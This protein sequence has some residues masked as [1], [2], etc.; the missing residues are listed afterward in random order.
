MKLGKLPYRPDDR[1]LLIS[2]YITSLLPPAPP[3]LDLT[4]KVQAWP[5]Y[6]NDK[7]GDCTC[8][9]AGHMIELWSALTGKQV[10]P[11]DRQIV[12]MYEKVGGYNPNAGSPDNNPTDN[13]AVELDVLSWWHKNSLDG[14][15]IQ[16]FALVKPT[17]N[18]HVRQTLQLFNGV[19]LGINLPKSAEAQVGR[20]W[21]VPPNGTSG[22]GAPG[23]WGG[24]AVNIVAYDQRTVTVVT[25]GTLQKMSWN[26]F[27]TYCDE[28]WAL[29][30]ANWK[31]KAPQ[32]FDFK[33]LQ[34][35]LAQIG[36]VQPII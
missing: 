32:G 24:H 8:A 3:T 2:N 20:L 33:A 5:M 7:I 10:T 29:L 25:W 15:K 13:G 14:F 21:D 6:S 9:A 1:T 27:N 19:Y 12:T 18:E 16:A 17:E 11:T 30:P 31:S 36:Q 22:D 34:N 4:T 23:S 26:F 28:A 35:D